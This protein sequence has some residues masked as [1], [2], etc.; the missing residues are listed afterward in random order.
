[1]LHNG[2]WHICSLHKA[3]C[4]DT[5]TCLG[6]VK[7]RDAFYRSSPF[8]ASSITPKNI[9]VRHRTTE[10]VSRRDRRQCSGGACT[11]ESLDWKVKGKVKRKRRASADSGREPAARTLTQVH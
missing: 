2:Q 4:Q 10:K 7:V 6:A 11:E 8:L 3:A 5:V 9:E 1:M